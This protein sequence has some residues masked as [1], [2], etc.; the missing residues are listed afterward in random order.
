MTSSPRSRR[1]RPRSRAQERAAPRAYRIFAYRE[2]SVD[3]VR[4]KKYEWNAGSHDGRT[5]VLCSAA[6]SGYAVRGL[7]RLRRRQGEHKGHPARADRSRQR[8]RTR[9]CVA[10]E[11]FVE[12]HRSRIDG[13]LAF[14]YQSTPLAIDGVLY[15]TTEVSQVAAL[16]GA[17]GETLW[18]F[19]PLAYESGAGAH[20]LFMHRG[21]SYWRSATEERLILGTVDGRLIAARS[22]GW[23]AHRFFWRARRGRL[24]S[25]TAPR[26]R[27]ERLFDFLTAPLGER[28]HRRGL[29]DHGREADAAASS[30]RCAWFRCP[31]R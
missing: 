21:L 27:A 3:V 4:K 25:G 22:G 19:D 7:A 23:A 5:L 17:T 26:R 10:V 9:D 29:V 13:T 18:S 8:R 31:D 24:D 6:S 2:V 1:K 12:R 28:C 16:D 11:V 20:S 15:A 30:R 14:T